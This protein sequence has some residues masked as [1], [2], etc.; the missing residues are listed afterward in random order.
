[1]DVP[2]TR[3]SGTLHVPRVRREGLQTQQ[4]VKFT[5]A[6][7]SRNDEVNFVKP[8]DRIWSMKH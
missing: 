2:K 7:R 1:M 3:I 8:E 5:L 6:V 4:G